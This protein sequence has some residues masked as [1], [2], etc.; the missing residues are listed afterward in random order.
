MLSDGEQFKILTLNEAG[1]SGSNIAR[2]IGR[3]KAAVNFFFRNP[4][5]YGSK[6]RAGRPKPLTERQSI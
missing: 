6:M 5:D 3:S 2:K 1:M 4:E